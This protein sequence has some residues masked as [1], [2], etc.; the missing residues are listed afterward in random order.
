MISSQC[1]GQQPNPTS[2]GNSGG[3]YRGSERE[4][5]NENTAACARRDS[6]AAADHK[7]HGGSVTYLRHRSN[8][9]RP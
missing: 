9:G 6:S 8:K 5:G 3:D 1:H 7:H 2:P 4:P